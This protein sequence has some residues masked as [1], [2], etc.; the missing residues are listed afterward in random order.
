MVGFFGRKKKEA[1]AVPVVAAPTLEALQADEARVLEELSG[2][3]EKIRSMQE[4]AVTYFEALKRENR[5]GY[6]QKKLEQFINN[7][8]ILIGQLALQFRSLAGVS[9]KY[10]ASN[11]LWVS[12]YNYVETIYNGLCNLS[13]VLN[14]RVDPT[15][16]SI[17]GHREWLYKAVQE[18][19]KSLSYHSPKTTVMQSVHA[20]VGQAVNDLLWVAM[21]LRE[22]KKLYSEE[23]KWRVSVEKIVKSCLDIIEGISFQ[24]G[25]S[26]GVG[27]QVNRDS[28]FQVEKEFS[29]GRYPAGAGIVELS[30]DIDAL[31][32]K[33]NKAERDEQAGQYI[34]SQFG[35][36]HSKI[37]DITKGIYQRYS[38]VFGQV[39]TLKGLLAASA[40]I[41]RIDVDTDVLSQRLK[42]TLDAIRDYN[43]RQFR[44]DYHIIS[45]FN[46]DPKQIPPTIKKY[47]EEVDTFRAAA[48]KKIGLLEAVER[49]MKEGFAGLKELV[50]AEN[51]F[52][53]RLEHG[54]AFFRQLDYESKVLEEQL[55]Q[56]RKLRRRS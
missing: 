21:Q 25:D 36:V 17:L 52:K 31:L 28:A 48:A 51:V 44:Y 15:D 40:Q 11:K 19:R 33:I 35:Q 6:D 1:P 29:N 23:D 38:L 27:L 24:G 9:D 55:R 41:E 20:G 49:K 37:Q 2:I 30:G 5:Q 34:A 53:Y 56:A 42:D 46:I 8:T 22:L 13:L 14:N 18:I 16:Q 43:E 47:N 10:D 54:E 32:V 3:R 50:S 26:A 39:M 12:Q 45:S 4:K 7:L